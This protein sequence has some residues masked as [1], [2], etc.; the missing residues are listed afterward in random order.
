MDARVRHQV[1][2]ELG[3]INVQGTVETERGGQRGD[4]LRDE[5][6]QVG[7]GGTLDIQGA[8]ADIVHGLVINEHSNVSVLQQRVGGEHGVVG[9][10]HGGGNLR[11][12]VNGESQL[13]LLAVVHRQTLQKQRAETGSSTAAYRVEAK[14]ALK[15]SAVVR[16]LANAVKAK[17]NNLLANGVVATGEVVGGILLSGDQLLRVEE[18]TVSSSADFINDSRLQVKKHAAG[19]VLAGTSLREEGVESIVTTTNGLV[20]R[21]LSIGLDAVFQAVKLPACVS[22]L[23]TGLA[24][25]DGDNFTHFY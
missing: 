20:G 25:V 17:V 16:K 24:N 1:G 21:H 15:T 14:E 2:L 19:H 23:N 22:D 10:H 5:T 3:H 7:V 11:R 18:L 12:R 8:T 9:F 6:V 13:R 4:N